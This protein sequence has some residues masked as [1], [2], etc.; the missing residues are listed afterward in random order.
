MT[1]NIPTPYSANFSSSNTA[2]DA[3]IKASVGSK[4]ESSK[5]VDNA[6]HHAVYERGSHS[7]GRTLTL[8]RPTQSDF[9]VSPE[10]KYQFTFEEDS[11]LLHHSK[12]PGVTTDAPVFF[13]SGKVITGSTPPML[14]FV[15]GDP[16]QRIR[17][18][19]PETLSDGSRIKLRNLKG[20]TLT[21]LGL[22]TDAEHVHAGQVVNVGLRTTDL[23]GKLLKGKLHSLNS[24]SVGYPFTGP[25]TGTVTTYKGADIAHHSTTFLSQS[26]RKTTLPHAI[27]YIGKHDHYAIYHDR[28]GNFIYAPDVFS[29]TDRKLGPSRAEGGTKSDPVVD[30]ANRVIVQGK[31]VALNDE[32]EASV[33]DAELQKKHGSVRT[34]RFID[35]TANTRTAARRTAS[36]M[37]RLNRKAQG[38]LRS[39]R[40]GSAWDLGPGDIIDYE[41]PIEGIVDRKAIV[42]VEHRLSGQESDFLLMSYER[43][44]EGVLNDSATL[45]VDEDTSVDKK[46]QI[47]KVE[48]SGIGHS[49][50]KVRGVMGAKRVLSSTN[51]SHSAVSGITMSNSGKNIHSGFILGHRGYVAGDS[52]G[53]GAIG[54]GV[55]A[56]LTGGTHSSGTITVT[57]TADF[58]SS[59]SLL[60]NEGIHASYTGKT[61]TTFTGVSVLAPTSGTV[62]ASG[63]SIRLLRPRSHE[64]TTLK[65]VAKRRRL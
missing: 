27:R 62:P 53:K 26:F 16:T 24:V 40:H 64:M 61:S 3:D 23:V 9:Q 21:E 36:Q 59:G 60:I 38:A 33:D 2:R 42:E 14:L 17:S 6:I 12:Q 54:I 13:D 35:P 32:N 56:R 25:R 49:N 37:L 47:E 19:T 20:K 10:R 4:I 51:R 43:G 39:E 55:S 45:T 65:G 18:D 63:L 46:A 31:K 7:S 44:I 29:Q 22:Q 34:Q 15:D 8:D 41:N 50:L 28:F 1:Y 11:L 57:S 30:V 48:K 52:S 58:P 5:F